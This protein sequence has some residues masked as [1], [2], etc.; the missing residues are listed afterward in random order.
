[1]FTGG[2]V[3]NGSLSDEETLQ[4]GSKVEGSLGHSSTEPQEGSN[5]VALLLYTSYFHSLGKF[6]FTGPIKTGVPFGVL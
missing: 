2:A 5:D 3:E 6:S 1:M 4:Q